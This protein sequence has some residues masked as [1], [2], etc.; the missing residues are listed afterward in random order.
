[1]IDWRRALIAGV[2]AGLAAA[3]VLVIVQ[4]ISVSKLTNE[5]QDF[6]REHDAQR[7]KPEPPAD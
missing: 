1:M 7:Q 5:I 6:L 3:V 4:Q 2:L